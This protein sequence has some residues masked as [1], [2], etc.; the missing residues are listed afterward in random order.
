[1]TLSSKPAALAADA[2]FEGADFLARFV[3]VKDPVLSVQRRPVAP[4]NSCARACR[5]Q[6][7]PGKFRRRR[8]LAALR[9]VLR[10]ARCQDRLCR[11]SLELPPPRAKL[12][13]D[14]RR[15]SSCRPNRG[16]AG[17]CAEGLRTCR[18]QSWR[19][20]PPIWM[21]FGLNCPA[22]RKTA[23]ARPKQS[24]SQMTSTPVRAA[25]AHSP[26]NWVRFSGLCVKADG[27]DHLGVLGHAGFLHELRAARRIAFMPIP[28][29]SMT[30]RLCLAM[31]GRPAPP[32][33]T[34]LSPVRDFWRRPCRCNRGRPTRIATPHGLAGRPAPAIAPPLFLRRV[35]GFE[36]GRSELEQGPEMAVFGGRGTSAT[37]PRGAAGMVAR[38]EMAEMGG[39]DG[40]ARRGRV[41]QQRFAPGR[42]APPG[43]FK[44]KQARRVLAWLS[45]RATALFSQAWATS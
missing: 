36:Q 15:A 38:V 9:R 44:I 39:C 29:I 37:P 40:V 17:F 22:R 1:M 33:R 23:T 20:R 26:E 16:Y 21:R 2:L 34:S 27:S 7:R 4:R 30:P 3:S 42:V 13:P 8:R 32:F 25:P 24:D 31:T 6:G 19:N 14:G 18:R 43:M 5:L 45:S 28:L 11:R 41:E 10:D 12:D 35:A